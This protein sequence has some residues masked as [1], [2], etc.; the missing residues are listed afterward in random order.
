MAKKHFNSTKY[1]Y[2]VLVPEKQFRR[3]TD[4]LGNP[5]IRENLGSLNFRTY[6]DRVGA[7]GRGAGLA[8]Q[9]VVGQDE[10]GRPKGKNFSLNQSHNAFK[11]N[12][13]DRDV[14]GTTM[15]EF[16]SNYPNCQDSPNGIYS[17]D[18]NGD[19]VQMNVEFRLMNSDADAEVALDATIN[20]TK[21]Q[22][23]A[24]DLDPQTLM[25]VAAIGIGLHGE[26][27]SVMRL[28]VSEWAGTRPNDYFE[29]LN[30]G[31]RQLRAVIRKAVADGIFREQGEL[32]YWGNT[33]IGTSEDAAVKFLVESPDS[34]A[35]LQEKMNLKVAIEP[36]KKQAGRPPN[37]KPKND[38]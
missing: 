17:V 16:L 22:A 23:S 33:M 19:R 29:V 12:E 35:A 21:A 26:A 14:H 24:L 3:D 30:S 7:L 18:A 9:Y 15:M 36:A 27:S 25:E 6:T 32:I 11:V 5:V 20:R 10:K 34:L 37:P 4:M 2:F 13:E 28:R 1:H 8:V 31:D 38:K